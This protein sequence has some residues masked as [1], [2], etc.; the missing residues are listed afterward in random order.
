MNTGKLLTLLLTWLLLSPAFR[1]RKFSQGSKQGLASPGGLSL[2]LSYFFGLMR[3]VI[4]SVALGYYSVYLCIVPQL[5]TAL[6]LGVCKC[7]AD[8]EFR[9][10]SFS[11]QVLYVLVGSLV[12]CITPRSDAEDLLEK[13][14][15]QGEAGKARTIKSEEFEMEEKDLLT[16][17][18]TEESNKV[19][20]RKRS[21]AKEL[22]GI[23]IIHAVNVLVGIAAFAILHGTSTELVTTET[24]VKDAS[25]ID[26][27]LSVYI[28][29]PVALLA[30]VFFRV[31]HAKLG[32]WRAI[33]PLP[34]TCSAICP[35]AF[36]SSE[37]LNKI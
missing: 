9:K 22:C 2:T 24:K 5:L 4:L 28:G 1:L 21:R 14:E 3:N 16:E 30:S 18:Q 10:W 23:F 35:P 26:L 8:K 29:C 17:D 31:I 37:E 12:P 11:D 15:N 32:P 25:K 7:V 6:I 34:S 27:M 13:E 36:T 33:N 20:I 19:I